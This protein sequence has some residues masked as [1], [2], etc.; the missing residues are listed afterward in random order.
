MNKNINIQRFCT[1][2][3]KSLYTTMTATQIPCILPPAFFATGSNTMEVEHCTKQKEFLT[4]HQHRYEL[5]KQTMFINKLEANA[6]VDQ[7]EQRSRFLACVTVFSHFFQKFTLTRLA[8]CCKEPYYSVFYDHYLEE[9]GHDDMLDQQV[10]LPVINDARLDALSNW[11]AYQMLVCDNIEKAAIH[12]VLET[13]GDH[14]HKVAEKSIGNTL[15]NDYYGIHAECEEH[16]IKLV[17]NLF[18]KLTADTYNELQQVIKKSWDV[19]IA[20]NQRM[21]SLI[22]Q[23][24]N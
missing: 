21:V 15:S 13:S 17:E 12:L 4:Y 7:P 22:E 19:I 14:Y 1:K 2:S 6:Y 24:P 9:L 16:H 3:A 20:M 8:T 23:Q 10:G 11:F 18:H 5:F